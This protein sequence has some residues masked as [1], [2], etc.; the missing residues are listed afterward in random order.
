M[1]PPDDDAFPDAPPDVPE[2]GRRFHRRHLTG[3]GLLAILPLIAAFGL[4]GTRTAVERASS[5]A[6]DVVVEYPTRV[7]ATQQATL[8]IL[9]SARAGQPVDG[10]RVSIAPGYLEHFV[11]QG[12]TPDRT[13]P[14]E[15]DVPALGPGDVA[16]VVV[17]LEAIRFGL[18]RGT[19]RID[20]PGGETLVVAI[21][22]FILP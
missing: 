11:V 2:I 14:G 5:A 10:L 15:V 13:A 22:T 7:R 20:G 1:N 9:T 19:I 3:L 4:L 6:L 21:R 17:E 8:R 12:A 18:H 16:S